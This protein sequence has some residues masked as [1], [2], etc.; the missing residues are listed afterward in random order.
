[1]ALQLRRRACLSEVVG[2]SW[3][4]LLPIADKEELYW[5]VG[6]IMLASLASRCKLKRIGHKGYMPSVL[7]TNYFNHHDPIVTFTSQEANKIINTLCT[8]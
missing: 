1:M 2:I 7:G 5:M 6:H 4:N 3:C 8:G